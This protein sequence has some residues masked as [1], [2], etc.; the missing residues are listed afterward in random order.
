[1]WPAKK[2]RNRNINRKNNLEGRKDRNGD[3]RLLLIIITIIGFKLKTHPKPLP[4][5]DFVGL[6]F[7]GGDSYGT[8]LLLFDLCCE[9]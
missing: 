4:G 9:P 6:A 8:T 5:G 2:K 3:L 1:M 7:P